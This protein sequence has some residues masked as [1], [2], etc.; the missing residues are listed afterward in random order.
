VAARARAIVVAA[1][2]MNAMI[3]DLLDAA[4]FE[5]GQLTLSPVTVDLRRFV[6]E[7]LE[8]LEGTLA[9]A[10][11][12]VRWGGEDVPAVRAD[13]N[14]LERIVVNLLSNALKYSDAEVELAVGRQGDEALISVADHGPGIDP[15]DLPGLFDRFSRTAKGRAQGVGLGLYSTRVL[16][17]A[18]GGRL[19]VASEPG[20]GATFSVALPVA[21]AP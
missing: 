7:L 17:E 19:S 13:P 9:V 4:R 6:S 12:R 15:A 2:R 14:R 16:V 11:I 8:R 21:P 1:G 18:H 5:R 20:R 10:R 3:Q